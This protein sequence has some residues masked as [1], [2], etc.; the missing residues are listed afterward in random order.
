MYF[1]PQKMIKIVNTIDPISSTIIDGVT[2]I[3]SMLKLSLCTYFVMNMISFY[4][5]T[6][7]YNFLGLPAQPNFSRIAL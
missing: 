2:K 7:M 4:T 3:Y 1:I 6:L 5:L